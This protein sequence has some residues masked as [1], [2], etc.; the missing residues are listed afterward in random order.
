[1][2][3]T[4]TIGVRFYSELL[5]LLIKSGEVKTAHQALKLYE[6]TYIESKKINLSIYKRSKKSI[7]APIESTM[8][9]KKDIISVNRLYKK[10]DPP[11]KSIAFSMKYGF[12]TYAELEQ[13]IK[14]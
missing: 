4:N 7:E 2:R 13:N 5:E 8:A 9:E 3:K 10:G 6:K 1:M 14:K 11:E 12:D